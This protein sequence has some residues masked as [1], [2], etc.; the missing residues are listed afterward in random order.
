MK[1][2]LSLLFYFSILICIFSCN[3]QNVD[4][5]EEET[6]VFLRVLSAVDST[7]LLFG[8]NKVYDI[9]KLKIYDLDT[10]DSTF[11]PV[12]TFEKNV[13]N[14]TLLTFDHIDFMISRIFIDFGNTDIDTLD[15]N[16]ETNDTE[17][18]S[19]F[20]FISSAHQN[21]TS[22]FSLSSGLLNIMK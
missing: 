7:D 14:D 8:A 16:F 2:L 21:G 22:I 11:Y 6:T 17:C 18:C 4:C 13:L 1:N 20:R 10:S 3:C 12:S 15:I 5:V 9:S 19:D